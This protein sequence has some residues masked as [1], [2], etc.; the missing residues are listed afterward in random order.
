[1]EKEFADWIEKELGKPI[2]VTKETYGDQSN[3]YHLKFSDKNYFLK[4]GLG[5]EK[6]REHL[7]LIF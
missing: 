6:E 1:M 3:V 7:D 5:L 4:I 2:S